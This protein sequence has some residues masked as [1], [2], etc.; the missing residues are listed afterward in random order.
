MGKDTK[1]HYYLPF[2]YVEKSQNRLGI[3]YVHEELEKFNTT[4]GIM[5]MGIEQLRIESNQDQQMYI[6]VNYVGAK[7]EDTGFHSLDIVK[8]FCS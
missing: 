1:I 3:S 2:L 7:R 5:P 6:Q 4:A 8:K